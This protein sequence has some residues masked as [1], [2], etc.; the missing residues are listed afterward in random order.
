MIIIKIFPDTRLNAPPTPIGLNPR[1]LLRDIKLHATKL[2]KDAQLLLFNI[3]LIHNF[4]TS[5]AIALQRSDVAVPKHDETIILHHPSTS[6]RNGPEPPVVLIATYL[7][8]FHQCCHTQ[9]DAFFV[10]VLAVLPVGRCPLHRAILAPITDVV[11]LLEVRYH[12]SYYFL[13]S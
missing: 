5:S 9:L 13:V 7:L 3:F 6:S 4:L 1:F 12:R 11:H 2:S 10:L 8:V